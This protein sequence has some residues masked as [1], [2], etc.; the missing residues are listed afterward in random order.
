[1]SRG[2]GDLDSEHVGS[3]HE[4]RENVAEYTVVSLLDFF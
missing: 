2:A 4:R 3:L 1:L